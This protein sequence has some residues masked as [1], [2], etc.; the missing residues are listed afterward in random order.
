MCVQS[1]D[2]F[3]GIFRKNTK[4]RANS[5]S[6]VKSKEYVILRG[7][8]TKRCEDY[9]CPQCV[10]GFCRERPLVL[11]KSNQ[12]KL[13]NRN[14]ILNGFS[15]MTDRGLPSNHTLFLTNPS[16]NEI[17]EKVVKQNNGTGYETPLIEGSPPQNTS[18]VQCICSW[19]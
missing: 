4:I 1:V 11:K 15:N 14:T 3:L 7:I 12:K 9:R 5:Q 6:S 17:T 19:I 13:L 16:H 18:S 8:E 2:R 10:P